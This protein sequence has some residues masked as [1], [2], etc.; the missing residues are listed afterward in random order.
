MNPA[1]LM[2]HA[3]SIGYALFTVINTTQIWGGVSPFLPED[4]QTDEVT[5]TFY[6]ARTIAFCTAF[7]ASTF[8][9]Y[10]FPAQ[11]RK[12]LISLSAGMV[13]AGSS[14]VIAAIY[15][16]VYTLAFVLAGGISTG[17]G[18]AGFFML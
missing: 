16:P 1:Q 10:Y 18:T 11:A 14:C 8:G 13:L 6:L 15:I 4:F 3:S 9:S 7:V 2:P 12:M 17:V 5:L